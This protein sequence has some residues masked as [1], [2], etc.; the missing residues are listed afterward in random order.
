[1]NM[2]RPSDSASIDE[3]FAAVPEGRRPVI[4]F[5]HDFIQE[6]TPEL[7][8]YWAT[9]MLGYG[10]LKYFDKRAKQ[11]KSWPIV[12]LANQKNY[13]SLYVCAVEDD[14]YLP[15]IYQDRLG[16]VNV[17]KSCIRFKKIEDLELEVL[18]ELLIRAQTSPGM[19]GAEMVKE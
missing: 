11:V 9:N 18:K 2:F 3:Y 7:R 6:V 12:A 16:R 17:G 15:E 13:I 5:L 1:M 19:V 14:Q 4:D 8:P 10:Q